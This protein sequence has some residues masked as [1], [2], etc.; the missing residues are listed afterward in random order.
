MMTRPGRCSCAIRDRV[1]TSIEAAAYVAELVAAYPSIREVWLYGSRANGTAREKSDWDYLAFADAATL[2]A[3]R[4][5]TRFDREGIDLMVVTDGVRFEQPWIDP[6]GKK[7]GTLA[8]EFGGMH[9]RKMSATEAR[10]QA[11]K[12]PAPGSSYGTRVFAQRAA[13]VHP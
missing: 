6:G 10:Y 9:W 13:R 4:R 1:L 3:L 12:P 2:A 7:E 11:T 8:P 5:E